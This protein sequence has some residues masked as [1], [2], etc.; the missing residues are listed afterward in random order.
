MS[1]R[2]E[3]EVIFDET[4][5]EPFSSSDEVVLGYQLPSFSKAASISGKMSGGFSSK[6]NL[7]RNA[8]AKK[9]PI[10]TFLTDAAWSV[11]DDLGL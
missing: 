5:F 2:D 4:Y 3:D 1:E 11:L 6:G 9:P 10:T 8:K 7:G